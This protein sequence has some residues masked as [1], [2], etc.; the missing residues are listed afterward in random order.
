MILGDEFL[1]SEVVLS[2]KCQEFQKIN[3]AMKSSKMIM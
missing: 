2:E 3:T 1:I